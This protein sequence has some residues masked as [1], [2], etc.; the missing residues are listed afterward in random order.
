MAHAG[1][2]LIAN[3]ESQGVTTLFTVP[4]ESFLA[5]LDGMHGSRIQPIICRQEGGAAMMAEAWGK[6]S[7]T[8]GILFVTRGPG[9]ANA[10]SGLHIAQQDSTPLIMF[11]GLPPLGHD[12]R[13]AFQEIDTKGVFG[14]FVKWAAV[15]RD[16]ERVG[17]YVSRA[18]H[19]AMSG[20]PGPVVLGLPEDMLVTEVADRAPVEAAVS[21]RAAPD[22]GQMRAFAQALSQAQRP[23]MICGGPGWSVDVREKIQAFAAHNA[24]PLASAFRQQDYIDNRHETYV[25]C[26]GIGIDEALADAIRQSDLLISVGARLGEMTT[27]GY[28]LVDSPQPKQKLVHVHPDPDEL[29]MVYRA[30]IPIAATAEAFVQALDDISPQV[31]DRGAHVAELRRAYETTLEPMVTPGDV[32]PGEV[33]ATMTRTLPEDAIITNGAGNYSAFLHRYYQY[34]GFRTQLGPTCGSMGYGLP[35]AVAA[36]LA[37]PE[38][39]VIAMAGDG[40]FMMTSQ[41]LAT[42]AQ[43]NLA[44]ITII[45]NNGMYG[46]IRMH[47][48]RDFP[49]RTV[50]TTLQNPDFAAFARAFGGHGETVSNTEDFEPALQRAIASG[51]PAVIEVT[52]DPEAL[53]PRRTLSQIR[54]G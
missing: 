23:L 4:G 52:I 9:A 49:E 27:S 35:A 3:L 29:G 7:G 48:E 31:P 40:C 33:I 45:F 39:I 24:I 14:T 51:K 54:A 46:T 25:G 37:A 42:A 12:D 18:F 21:V 38:K 34:K 47:Q 10:M 13:D 22:A 8:P 28:T 17:E 53:T 16:P 50:A 2:M 5:A 43:Y 32:Q 15:V 36:K 19:V 11:L 20:R 41:E 44:V 6:L 1:R 30:D 26:A